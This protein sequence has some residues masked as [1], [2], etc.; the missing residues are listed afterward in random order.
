[1]GTVSDGA[2]TLRVWSDR[3]EYASVSP[4]SCVFYFFPSVPIL[5]YQ[6][7]YVLAINPRLLPRTT[8][9]LVISLTLGKSVKRLCVQT[10]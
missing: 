2:S 1:M 10:M 3:H 7:S 5:Y 9:S 6:R 8:E 4:L